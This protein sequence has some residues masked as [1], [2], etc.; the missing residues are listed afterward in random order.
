MSRRTSLPASCCRFEDARGML[1][2]KVSSYFVTF[3][4]LVSLEFWVNE[5]GEARKGQSR[6]AVADML[7]L[8]FVNFPESCSKFA[9]VSDCS[10]TARRCDLEDQAHRVP[11]CGWHHVVH[12]QPRPQFVGT[13]RHTA[14]EITVAVVQGEHPELT[15]FN[16]NW[17]RADTIVQRAS[18]PV[19]SLHFPRKTCVK[20]AWFTNIDMN[21]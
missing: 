9:N 14:D 20:V 21:E 10:I 18:R 6:A 16:R 17:Q 13:T 2:G 12:T 7:K 19:D 8:G 4:A 15:T 3:H 5:W 1:V 11:V